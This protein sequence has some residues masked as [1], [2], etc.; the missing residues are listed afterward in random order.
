MKQP[1]GKSVLITGANN[2]LGKDV[3]RQLAGLGHFGTIY[4]ACRNESKAQ[5]ARAELRQVPSKTAFEIVLMDTTDLTS[6]GSAVTAIRRPLDAVVLNAGGTGGKT[7]LA[8]TAEGVTTIFATNVLG[9]VVLLEQLIEKGMLTSTS[10]L[11]GSEA[12]RGVPILRIKRPVFA[13]HSVDE[14]VAVLDGS[15]FDGRK[16]DPTL[17]YAQ[18]KYLGA[19]WMS[20]LARRHPSL[21]LLT[22]SPGYTSGTDAFRDLNVVT[23]TVLQRIV[24]PYLAPAFGIAHKLDVGAKRL[25]D[26]VTDESWESGVFYASAARALTGPLID[27]A[28]IVLDFNNEAIQDR[29]DDAIHR[30]VPAPAPGSFPRYR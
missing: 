24:M 3:A 28:G 6:V 12:A 23:R 10:V 13:D 26:A 7:P 18:V 4:L 14:F 17:A 21:R 20:A 1:E 2:G 16:F 27:Q 9:H 29:A 30:F 5:A 22:V 15:F 8:L 19:L 25:V 11:T